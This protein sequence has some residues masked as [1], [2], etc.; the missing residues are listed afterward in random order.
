M[1][2]GNRFVRHGGSAAGIAYKKTRPMK[3]RSPAVFFCITALGLIPHAAHGQILVC[4][5]LIVGCIIHEPYLYFFIL[6]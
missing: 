4:E 1:P 3:H 5:Y 2:G 6:I